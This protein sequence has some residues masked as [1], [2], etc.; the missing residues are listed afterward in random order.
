[1][2]TWLHQERLNAVREQVVMARARTILDL[3]CGS[4][5]LLI[6]LLDDP[7]IT[8]IT[9][10]DTSAQALDRLRTRLARRGGDRRVE[11]IHGSMTRPDPRLA[12]HDCALL[13]ETIE[14]LDPE[15]L[16]ALEAAVFGTIRPLTAV[17][18]TPNA[19]F[20][21]LLGVPAHRFRHPGHR[22]EWP[23]VRFR[24]WADGLARRHGYTVACHDIGGCHPDLG[25]ASQMAFLTRAG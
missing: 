16:S 10:L 14:H 3:G 20:N 2:T 15:Q 18:T 11:L 25:G 9:G 6:R 19:E 17:V 12:G 21:P 22:F 5:D 13:V 4:G 23:R 7:R 24:A 8:R 1:M